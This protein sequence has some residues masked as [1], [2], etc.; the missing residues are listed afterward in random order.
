MTTRIKTVEYSLA[1]LLPAEQA[2]KTRVT[3]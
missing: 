3:T 1:G 2:K